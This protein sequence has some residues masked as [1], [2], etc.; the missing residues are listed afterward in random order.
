M[1]SKSK[2]T[3]STLL[4][5]HLEPRIYI[6]IIFH[7]NSSSPIHCFDRYRVIVISEHNSTYAMNLFQDSAPF[8]ANLSDIDYREKFVV[9]HHTS[10][11]A[12]A[13]KQVERSL[14]ESVRDY[15]WCIKLKILHIPYI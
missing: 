2:C 1:F 5:I 6:N 3:D 12:I 10:S 15:V 7:R 8:A 9:Q 13:T 4:H 14:F 11:R